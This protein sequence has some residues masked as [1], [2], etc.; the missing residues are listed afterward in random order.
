[1][2]DFPDLVEDL[3]RAVSKSREPLY[4]IAARSPAPVAL[5]RDN[6]DAVLANPILFRTYF[7]PEYEEQAAVL[8][9]QGKLMAV[10]MDGR[11]RDLKELIGQTP[12]DILE[13]FHPP[14]MGDL[15][16]GEAL[17]TW[18]GKAIWVGFPGATYEFGPEA[19]RQYALDLL[20]EVG[21]GDR[22]AI[23]MS[24]E[25]QVSNDNLMALTDV[26]A[27]ATLPLD[28]A[29]IERILGMR[30]TTCLRD[31]RSGGVAC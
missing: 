17:A 15:P 3:Y 18:P 30:R 25:G 21:A 31:A 20:R 29:A 7:M 2:A 12:I 28:P 23:A 24:T 19:T 1:M 9:R 27:S 16:I 13:A 8:H 14:P 5:C 6:V 10:Y 26:L 11:L 4:E 22:L